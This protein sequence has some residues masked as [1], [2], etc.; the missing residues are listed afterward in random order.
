MCMCKL[1]RYS[2]MTN[3]V[4]KMTFLVPV[5]EL[6]KSKNSVPLPKGCIFLL[7]CSKAP[8]CPSYQPHTNHLPILLSVC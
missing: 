5:L 2:K 6:Y 8:H 7:T 1:Y 3:K 4:V